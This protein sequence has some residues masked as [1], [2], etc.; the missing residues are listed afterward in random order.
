MEMKKDERKK[1]EMKKKRK[2]GSERQ[3]GFISTRPRTT[4]HRLRGH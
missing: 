1:A 4:L 3:P 2:D